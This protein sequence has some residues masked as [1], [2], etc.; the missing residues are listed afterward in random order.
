MFQ[1][2]SKSR[3]FTLVE[4]L[5]VIAIIGVLV[6]LLLPAVQAA[7]E[8]ARRMNCQNNLKQI[9]LACHNFHDVFGVLPNAYGPTTGLSWHVYILPYIE[10]QNLYNLFDTTTNNPSHTAANRNDPHGLKIIPT[11]Q[12]ASCPLKRQAFGPP[13]NT[14]GNTDLIPPNTGQ[15]A[16]IPHYYGINGPRGA[17]YGPETAGTALHETVP[18]ART[19]MFQRDGK[20]RLAS[21]TD[22][23]SNTLMIAEMSWVSPRFGTR[24]RTWPRGGDE[25]NGEVASRPSFVVSCRNVTNPINAMNT[26]NLIVPYNDIPFGSMHPGGMNVC[27]G[28]ASVRFLNQTISMAAYR[29]LASRDQGE[30]VTID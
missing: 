6:A 19:G 1:P 16:A 2:G 30:T 21:V 20:I 29:A 12:C 25:Y 18:A 27:L 24:Y 10:Q 4:L 11:Y 28:D 9:G 23:T 15:P 7:R 26:A 13:N 5:V 14:N 17:G 3:G 22:G 8:A